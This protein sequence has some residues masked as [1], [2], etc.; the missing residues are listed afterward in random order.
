[1]YLKNGSKMAKVLTEALLPTTKLLLTATPLQNNLMELFG[2]VSV[3]ESYIFLVLI[4]HSSNNMVLVEMNKVLPGLG[5]DYPLLLSQFKK[6]NPGRGRNSLQEESSTYT[7]F[8][9][10]NN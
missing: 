2:L 10:I 5:R 9:T 4:L 3:I 8:H 1:V 6:T 7:R